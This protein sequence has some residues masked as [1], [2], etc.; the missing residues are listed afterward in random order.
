M[1]RL[2]TS[3]RE[4][5][6]KEDR[7]YGDP[8][9]GSGDFGSQ[10]RIRRKTKILTVVAGE[11]NPTIQRVTDRPRREPVGADFWTTNPEGRKRQAYGEA[12]TR[13]FGTTGEGVER[14]TLSN[15]GERRPG[16]GSEIRKPEE[17]PS[18][19]FQRLRRSA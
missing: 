17:D 5:R 19:R 13:Y 4:V 1:R 6:R 16:I 18:H 8:H 11:R 15:C 9:T 12:G 3:S 10:H 14:T 7:S 2:T